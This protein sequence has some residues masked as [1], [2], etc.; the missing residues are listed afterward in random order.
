MQL[1]LTKTGRLFLGVVVLLYFA[2]L[3]SQSGLLL[4]LVGIVLGCFGVNLM[5]AWFGVKSLRLEAPHSVH[6]CEGHRLWQ[7][8]R[9][10]NQSRRPVGFILA[11]SAA[12]I[13]FRV[14]RLVAGEETSVVPDLVYLQRGV[15]GHDQV[16]LSSFYP[17]GLVRA[18]RELPLPGEVVVHPA[19]YETEPPRAA[20]Y[21]VMVGGKHKGQR[22][23]SS[24]L[25]FAGV[26]PFEPGDP[27][28]QIHWRSSAKGQGLMVKTYE[29][30]LSG[31]V[32][33]I[34]DSGHTGSVKTLD[35]C[36]RAAG[37]LMFAALDAGHHIEWMDLGEIEPRLVPPFADGHELLDA[38]ARLRAQPGCLT[39][40]RLG[41]AMEKLPRKGAVHLVLTDFNPAVAAALGRLRDQKRRVSVYLPANCE[42][43][44]RLSM[45]V[46]R[47]TAK[48]ILTEA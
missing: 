25:H 29:E 5:A 10:E 36:L 48:S 21:D 19:L 46:A 17:F 38:L 37:S 42:L 43:G 1:H 30:E 18:T 3:T 20:G 47:Y 33:F 13:L 16:K 32:C 40:E 2:S 6:L 14:A 27:L 45:P 4:L 26:R 15:Y 12:G 23:V 8:W 24:G 41:Q 11:E 9:L 44:A 34:L 35:D 7:P 28:K 39:A 22:R 31:R